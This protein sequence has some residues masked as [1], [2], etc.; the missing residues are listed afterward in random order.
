MSASDDVRRY[1]DG[2]LA[3]EFESL[4]PQ[5]WAGAD[6]MRELAPEGWATSPL[7]AIYHPTAAQVHEETVR[8]RRN[9]ENLPLTRRPDA[10]PLAE[11]TAEHV[12]SPVEADRE[13]QELVGRCLWDIFCDNHG[14]VAE[15]SRRLDLG[16]MR[17]GGGFLA[18]VLNKQDGPKPAERPE[19]PE[20]LMKMM[21]GD[22]PQDE[23]TAAFMAEMI[24]EMVGDGGYTYL[25]F[26]MGTTMMS[27]RADLGPVYALIF[28]RL[29]ARGLDWVYHF[30][31]L[32]AVD[33]RPLEK[34]LD[35]QAKGD[36]PE[37]AG[38]DPSAALEEEQEETQKDEEIAELRA[39][40]DEGHREA[41]EASRDRPPP[42]TVLAYEA[43]YGCFPEGWPPEG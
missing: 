29:R 17:A 34:Q 32:Y 2:E 8:M 25:D 26:Y 18:D 4:F 30:P 9:I 22:A 13:L 39:S 14:V 28:R 43:V 40:L 31:R 19:P 42:A 23:K 37:W 12:D 36:E 21:T 38:Y 1:D 16:S 7:C 3:A 41:V 15:D 35:E 24:K 27:G 6:V 20:F 10:P 33:M 11:I 5:G